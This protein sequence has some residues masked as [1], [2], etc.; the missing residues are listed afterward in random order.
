MAGFLEKLIP[1]LTKSVAQAEIPAQRA[2]RRTPPDDQPP[3][4]DQRRPQAVDARGTGARARSARSGT[5]RDSTTSRSRSARD[6][7]VAQHLRGARRRRAQ[8]RRPRK[9]TA[10]RKRPA[11]GRRAPPRRKARRASGTL[12]ADAHMS[13]VC[14]LMLHAGVSRCRLAQSHRPRKPAC[15]KSFRPAT[16]NTVV[17]VRPA[18]GCARRR[19]TKPSAVHA[20]TQRLHVTSSPS[21]RGRAAPRALAAHRVVHERLAHPRPDALARDHLRDREGGGGERDQLGAEQ[22]RARPRRGGASRPPGPASA[23]A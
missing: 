7:T 2:Q 22:L 21:A 6:V 12:S 23:S 15:M 3:H 4:D 5:K 10:A 8:A 16:A 13:T 20:P 14:A 19:P 17:T 1:R 18:R 11:A 9:T